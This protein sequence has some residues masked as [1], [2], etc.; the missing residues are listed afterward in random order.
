MQCARCGHVQLPASAERDRALHTIAADV[1]PSRP[2]AAMDAWLSAQR[3]LPKS[4]ES[5]LLVDVGSSKGEMLLA[6]SRIGWRVC[7]VEPAAELAQ[8]ANAAGAPSICAYF[9]ESVAREIRERYGSG[10]RA[11]VATNVIANV[12]QLDEFLGAAGTALDE[13]GVLI[14]E[15]QYL[16]D[17]IEGV[18]L[19]TIHHDHLSYFS[20]ESLG[21]ALGRA[22]F[23]IVDIERVPAKGGSLRAAARLGVGHGEKHAALVAEERR[24]GLRDAE[25]FAPFS[26]TLQ[27]C[28]SELDRLLGSQA[29]E[30]VAGYGSSIGCGTVIAQFALEGRLE[31]LVDESIG[32][33]REDRAFGLRV[34]SAGELVRSAPEAVVVL[35]WRFADQIATKTRE[36]LEGGGAFIV[37]LREVH[38][39][40]RK[41]S[42]V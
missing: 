35:A 21:A 13:S 28:A 29:Y 12:E 38:V 10:A 32:E 31:F 34:L 15:T 16:R 33:G 6:A 2:A 9:D 19:D 26:R 39:I 1:T 20:A 41:G 37:P 17:T 8:A 14:V 4:G 23:G 24:A 25:Y 42:A 27:Q 18:M 36:Y 5:K 3:T 40:G 30:R 22:G 7:G 11:I